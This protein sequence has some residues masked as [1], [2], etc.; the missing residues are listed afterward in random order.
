MKFF[1]KVNNVH[2]KNKWIRF[3]ALVVVVGIA[4]SMSLKRNEE[5]KK[6]EVVA[7][8][9]RQIVPSI[10]ASGT[11]TYG[12]E[13]KIVAEQ[14]SRV[15]EILVSEGERVTKGQLVARLDSQSSALEVERLKASQHR[16]ELT[17]K[18][19]RLRYQLSADNL[20]RQSKLKASGLI[21]NARFD[22]FVTKKN[23]AAMELKG[24]EAALNEVTASLKQ[25]QQSLAKMEIRSP[26]DGMI[27][28]VMIEEGEIAVP[29]AMSIAGSTL[30]VISDTKTRYAEINIDEA[31]IARVQLGQ[32]AKIV[33]VAF[34][35]GTITGVVQEIALTAHQERGKAKS[36]PVKIFLDDHSGLKFFQGMSCRAEI[37]ISS[38]D[39]PQNLS[40]PIQAVQYDSDDKVSGKARPTV[41][42]LENGIAVKKAVVVGI[43]DDA[44][45]EVISGLVLSDSVL[46]GPAKILNFLR[47]GE[48]VAVADKNDLLVMVK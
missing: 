13:V 2:M 26:V 40:V 20:K 28:S 32:R 38:G 8:E 43:S 15:D 47:D 3:I 12:G 4:I 14:V 5:G 29:S 10:L 37:E 19:Q 17:I 41:F 16:A 33:P 34:P 18:V 25:T 48:M 11:L 31:D 22:D 9:K 6:V 46:I 35:D 24:A 42:V 23:I 44:Y 1:N 7:V 30:L 39:R 27:T 21:D 45:I 36:Y